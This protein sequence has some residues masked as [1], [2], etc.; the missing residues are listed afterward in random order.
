MHNILKLNILDFYKKQIFIFSI[1]LIFVTIN[2]LRHVKHLGVFMLRHIAI[3]FISLASFAISSDAKQHGK[4]HPAASSTS[5]YIPTQASLVVDAHTGRILHAEKAKEKIY[6]ASTI[7]MMT[8]YLAF[9]AIET[10]QLSMDSM[11]YVSKNP[12]KTKPGK[13]WVKEGERISL[14]D[15][16]TAVHVKSANDASV[17]IAEAI[18]GTEEKFVQLMNKKAK[19]LGMRDTHFTNSHGWHHPQQH[20]TAVDLAKLILALET[21]HGK[22]AIPLMRKKT[23]EHKGQVINHHNRVLANYPGATVGKTG[24]HC[25]GG[26]NN[27]VTVERNGKKLIAVVTGG[28]THQQR[29]KKMTALLDTHFGV[30]KPTVINTTKPSVKKYNKVKLANANYKNKKALKNR[31][32]KR[33]A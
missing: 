9:D 15:A 24:F 31:R 33:V 13:I 5:Q 23:F 21:H 19:E 27:A 11:L 29:D 20:S 14:R 10:G 18:S 16:I 22:Y 2:I 17:V 6:P 1:W 3:I 26:F 8:L 30:E 25:P 32:A 28:A 7:K 4:K 12:P